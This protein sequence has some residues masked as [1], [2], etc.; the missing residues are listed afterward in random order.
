M[1]YSELRVGDSIYNEHGYVHA[2]VVAVRFGA[3]LSITWDDGIDV[4]TRSYDEDGPFSCP[5]GRVLKSRDGRQ[6]WP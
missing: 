2:T 1:K 4:W 6:L 5:E 3:A